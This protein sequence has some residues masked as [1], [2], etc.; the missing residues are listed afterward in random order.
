MLLPTSVVGSHG[1]PGWVWLA[2]EAMDAGR[3]GALD[4][5]ELM[6]DATQVALLDQERAG[7]D[8][9]STGEMMRV[10]FIIGFYDRIQGIRPLPAAR[11]LGQPLGYANAP[12]EVVETTSAPRGLG[13]V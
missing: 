11:K 13:I 6:E 8:V 3:L 4:V 5:Q 7:V 9:L 2:R 12:F 10:R 1:L